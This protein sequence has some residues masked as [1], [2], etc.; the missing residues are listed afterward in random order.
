M[1]PR[2]KQCKQNRRSNSTFL[3]KS[4]FQ[5]L[6]FTARALYLALIWVCGVLTIFLWSPAHFMPL[7]APVQVGTVKGS[8]SSVVTVTL[9]FLLFLSCFFFDFWIINKPLV[10]SGQ[11]WH[12]FPPAVKMFSYNLERG[13]NL[14]IK[15]DPPEFTASS[16][17]LRKSMCL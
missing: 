16:S 9:S 14:G 17:K 7:L 6:V 11:I 8:F 3:E 15:Q 5:V 1:P 13:E 12:P 4:H 10:L 2:N